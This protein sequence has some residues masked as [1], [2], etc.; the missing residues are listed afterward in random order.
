MAH[1]EKK[2]Q[3]RKIYDG[4]IVH[5]RLDEV[6]LE[7]GKSAMREVID[8]PGGV[9]V[10]PI[11]PDGTI[12]MVRQFRYAHGKELLELPAGKLEY[13]EDPAACGLREL[14]EEVGREAGEYHS[15]GCLYPTPAYV[16][17][18]IHLYYAAQLTPVAQHLDED[19][20]L[21]IVRVP[22]DEALEMVLDG[23][24]CDAKTQLALLKLDVLRRRGELRIG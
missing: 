6:E 13:G 11:E 12:L 16:T 10:A 22:F 20:F 14:A 9:C 15:L 2:L 8:H 7:N 3:S 1:L 5:L 17:E 24:I 21:D 18:V 19:E 4:R 23:R